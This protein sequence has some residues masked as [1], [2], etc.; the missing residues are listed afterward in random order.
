MKSRECANYERH[1]WMEDAEDPRTFCTHCEIE[2]LRGDYE[3]S[4]AS[5]VHADTAVLRLE[6]E[7]EHLQA[8][9]DAALAEVERL[10]AEVA[11]QEERNA[12]N[13]KAYQARIDAALA[14]IQ[15]AL[16]SSMVSGETCGQLLLVREALEEKK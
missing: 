3:S 7:V 13:V 8:R 15:E 5:R 10:R 2:R 4:H 16:D 14:V 11:W 6:A 12:M 1:G 9:I